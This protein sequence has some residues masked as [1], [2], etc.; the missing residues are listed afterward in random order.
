ML[1]KI[2][3]KPLTIV[4]VGFNQAIRNLNQISFNTDKNI[5]KKKSQLLMMLMDNQIKV[6]IQISEQLEVLQIDY[7]GIVPI[8]GNE[9]DY[10]YIKVFQWYE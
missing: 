2:L 1:L 7:A 3:Q 10:I 4:K 6:F 9:E 8:L 5:N